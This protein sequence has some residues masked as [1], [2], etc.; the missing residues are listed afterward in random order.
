MSMFNQQ[1][2]GQNKKPAMGPPPGINQDVK[3]QK[4]SIGQTQRNVNTN[5]GGDAPMGGL[6]GGSSNNRNRNRNRNKNN[7]NNNNNNNN[8][9]NNNNNNNQSNFQAAPTPTPIQSTN[10]ARTQHQTATPFATLPIAAPVQRAISQVLKYECMTDVQAQ[11]C[12]KIIAEQ[13][14]C[15]AKAKTGTGKT[16]AFLLPTIENILK[17]NNFNE[18]GRVSA[19][20]LS[21]TR[22]LA[23]QIADEGKILTSF[24]N[25]NIVCVVG[26]TNI[27]TD[28]K[29]LSPGVDILVA[30]PGRMID[31]LENTPGFAQKL[32]GSLKTL[33]MD[34][35]D[36][37]RI[38]SMT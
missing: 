29:R 38:F 8:S 16:I 36:Q 5:G 14:D 19:L 27:N 10:S 18:A 21:P 37:V 4:G 25:F 26:G 12:P 30:T 7:S 34:E 1:Y 2:Q 20:V 13:N 15:L 23:A 3:R 35:A 11:T 28:K 6:N 17:Q 22:E 33:I 31:H 32:R 24:V 9:N